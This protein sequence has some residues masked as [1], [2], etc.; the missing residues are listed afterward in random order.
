MINPRIKY[1]DPLTSMVNIAYFEDIKK[2]RF[3]SGNIQA[4][5]DPDG[6]NTVNFV[7]DWG[8]VL[9]S[10]KI[11]DTIGKTKTN[12]IL[13]I[14]MDWGNVKDRT[15]NMLKVIAS[16][17]GSDL[18]YITSYKEG[19]IPWGDYGRGSLGKAFLTATVYTS[20]LPDPALFSSKI[21]DNTKFK[22]TEKYVHHM[23]GLNGNL[24]H[25]KVNH[26]FEIK[27]LTLKDGFIYAD[28]KIGLES[29]R[30]RV[31]YLDDN[32]FVLSFSNLTVPYHYD[33]TA[34]FPDNLNA[35]YYYN[36]VVSLL[37]LR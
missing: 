4:I 31:V 25:Q 12:E 2:V 24:I 1:E 17:E 20:K 29:G 18:A 22:V 8:K 27:K 32:F 26:E 19:N 37:P 28:G 23:D 13:I 6:T 34:K 7:E 5:N 36:F 35:V 11:K 14:G 33:P 30:F 16:M 3:K 9:I 21:G 10:K 15:Y